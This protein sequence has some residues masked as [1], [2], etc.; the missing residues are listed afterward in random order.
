M[1]VGGC[2]KW[3]RWRQHRR[4]GSFRGTPARSSAGAFW[5]SSI[6]GLVRVAPAAPE[7][8]AEHL[9]DLYFAHDGA[10]SEAQKYERTFPVRTLS[11]LRFSPVFGRIRFDP[12][13]RSGMFRIR[14][15]TLCDAQDRPLLSVRGQQLGHVWHIGGT[16]RLVAV[17]DDG[18]LV[19]S[20][21][22]DRWLLLRVE[23]RR[24]DHGFSITIDLESL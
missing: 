23:D 20:T 3:A 14:A 9:S 16:A 4:G 5:I 11:R 1:R 8:P 6:V 17:A 7:L 2:A 21:G 22:I 19:E 10:F 12:D 15:T 18:L 13:V 24:A